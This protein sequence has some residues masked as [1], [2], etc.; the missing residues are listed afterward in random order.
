M[1]RWEEV[2]PWGYGV[3]TMMPAGS[4][5]EGMGGKGKQPCMQPSLGTGTLLLHGPQCMSQVRAPAPYCFM[6]PNACMWHEVEASRRVA[7]HDG[8]RLV[9][10]TVWFLRTGYRAFI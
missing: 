10:N 4:E 6:V 8:T 7:T 2:P 1:Q 9:L 3:S 5:L